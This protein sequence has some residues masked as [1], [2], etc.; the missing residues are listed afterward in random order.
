MIDYN[1]TIIYKLCC[2]NTA[3]TEIYIGYTTNLKGRIGVHR[4]VCI[5]NIHKSHNQK[6]YRFI[7]EN[8]GW[9]NW[10]FEILEEFSCNSKIEARNTEKVWFNKLK[11][12]L[13]TNI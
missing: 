8:G 1:K 4:R 7:R 9:D 11:P 3:I 12:T 10:T 13:N 6:P 5:Y 2:K